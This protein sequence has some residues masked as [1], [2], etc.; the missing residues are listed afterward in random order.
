MAI[1]KMT[2]DLIGKQVNNSNIKQSNDKKTEAQN[3][4]G[5]IP[6]VRINKR[7]KKILEDHFKREKGLNLSSGVRMI[8]FEYMKK[9]NLI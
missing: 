1:K 2:V 7:H 3:L 5:V 6:P 4:N 8:I 9:N